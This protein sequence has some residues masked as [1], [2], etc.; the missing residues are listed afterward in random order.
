MPNED[1]KLAHITC[2]GEQSQRCP[3][4]TKMRS[5]HL[6]TLTARSLHK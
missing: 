2:A 1:S 6:Q 5:K 3:K 4:V